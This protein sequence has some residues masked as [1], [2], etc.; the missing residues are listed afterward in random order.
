MKDP[1]LKRH[2]AKICILFAYHSLSTIS[3]LASPL[4]I[5]A[6]FCEYL[7]KP[8]GISKTQPRLSWTF[9]HSGRKRIQSNY[10]IVVSE[11]VNGN[12]NT[13]WVS[14]KV[15]S[16]AISNIEYEGYPLKSFTRYY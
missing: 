10:E 4:K 15:Y 6:L 14:G 8:L 9:L 12:I 3:C 5:E 2:L 16:L 1:A 7:E 13:V 11:I